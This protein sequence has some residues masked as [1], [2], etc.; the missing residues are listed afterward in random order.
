MIKCRK[1]TLA[2]WYRTSSRT[3]HI[4]PL[5][6]LLGD[7]RWFV[8]CCLNFR[9]RRWLTRKLFHQRDKL[10]ARS[11]WQR[12][13]AMRSGLFG[14]GDCLVECDLA[15]LCTESFLMVLFCL[16]CCL[17]CLFSV[18]QRHIH[19]HSQ[20]AEILKTKKYI[21]VDLVEKEVT[22]LYK[23]VFLAL[24]RWLTPF[25]WIFTACLGFDWIIDLYLFVAYKIMPSE[26]SFHDFYFRT[27][28]AE[29]IAQHVA[30]IYAAKIVYATTGKLEL[31]IDCDVS[32]DYAMRAVATVP[33]GENPVCIFAVVSFFHQNHAM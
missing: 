19:D 12:Y 6:R 14:D 8:L 25:L 1:Y 11:R 2:W 33:G 3:I 18:F 13:V 5:V 24:A 26:L 16:F 7:K 4:R 27:T 15:G 21:P 31:S 20:V 10:L 32:E 29:I 23:Y 28:P 30:A 9:I 22:Y 17:V